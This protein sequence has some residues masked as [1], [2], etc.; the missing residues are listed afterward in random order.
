MGT[1]RLF[2][3][4]RLGVLARLASF[5]R[6]AA[7]ESETTDEILAA[8]ARGRI[9]HPDPMTW[10]EFRGEYPP[11]PDDFGKDFLKDRPR[12]PEIRDGVTTFED[13]TKVNSREPLNPR[14]EESDSDR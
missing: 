4:T 8:R 5:F 7:G 12:I 10:E 9:R 3:T 2:K 14:G 11:L 6:P 13:G 1:L